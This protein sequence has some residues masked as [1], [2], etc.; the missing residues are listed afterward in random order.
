MMAQRTP[1]WP[2]SSELMRTS[3]AALTTEWGSGVPAPT[4][5]LTIRLRLRWRICSSG[6]TQVDSEPKPVLTPYTDL[7]DDTSDKTR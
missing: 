1:E 2:R 3:I 4:A 6:M 5:W 7:V